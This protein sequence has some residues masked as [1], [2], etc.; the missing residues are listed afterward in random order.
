MYSTSEQHSVFSA[1]HMQCWEVSSAPREGRSTTFLLCPHLSFLVRV[2]QLQ[3]RVQHETCK[4]WKKRDEVLNLSDVTRM[5]SIC[6]PHK[7]NINNRSNH[8][9][10]VQGLVLGSREHQIKW[11]QSKSLTKSYNSGCHLTTNCPGKRTQSQPGMMSTQGVLWLG[12]QGQ[13][14]PQCLQYNPRQASC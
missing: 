2:S 1:V 8:Q 14:H 9:F 5:D 10:L 3:A 4:R 11:K 7:G 13:P 12:P 6:F